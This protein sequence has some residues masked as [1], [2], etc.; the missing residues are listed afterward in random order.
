SQLRFTCCVVPVGRMAFID[1]ILNLAVLLLWVNWRSLCRVPMIS[2][3]PATLAGTLKRTAP[4]RLKSWQVLASLI[5]IEV[6]RAL[7]YYE[8]GAPVNWTPKLDLGFVVLAFR[9]DSLRS[10]ALYSVLSSVRLL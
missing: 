8:I 1:A 4:N 2:P 10:T 9:N 6:L 7:F 5:L 3:K